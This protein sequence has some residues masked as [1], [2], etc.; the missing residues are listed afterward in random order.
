MTHVSTGTLTGHAVVLDG[1]YTFLP[2][3]YGRTKTAELC[4]RVEP[5]VRTPASSTS[6]EENI[7]GALAM[8]RRSAHYSCRCSAHTRKVR[9]VTLASPPPPPPC[10]CVCSRARPSLSPCV[11]VCVC[12]CVRARE[13]ERE[14]ESSNPVKTSCDWSST[15]II[16]VPKIHP[17]AGGGVGGGGGKRES[18]LKMATFV[19]QHLLGKN[20]S[21]RGVDL[22][23]TRAVPNLPT[24]MIR[25]AQNKAQ[26]SRAHRER[27]S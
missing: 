17:R 5:S 15:P 4:N 26:Q 10:V 18:A 24:V 6:W 13:R 8:W 21:G 23:Y 27:A 2:W 1:R 3:P 7:G 20:M 22:M 9:N 12:V 11:C 14:R 16:S 19:A 25:A